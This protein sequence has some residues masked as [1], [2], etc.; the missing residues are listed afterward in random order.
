MKCIKDAKIYK[1][2]MSYLKDFLN[3]Y[4]FIPSDVLQR[5]IEANI[6][7]LCNFRRSI[8]EIGI[9]NGEISAGLFK[10]HSQID[11]GIDVDNSGLE[12]ARATNKYKK[13]FCINAENM[14]FKSASFN[15]VVS[16][17]SFEHII[18]DLKAVSEV[19][20]VLKKGGYF[21]VTVP[22]E[23]LPQWVLS[24]EEKRNKNTAKEKL[25]SFNNRTQHFHYHSF[26]EWRKVF[27]KNNLSIVFHKYYF[28]QE[29]I[30]F[31]YKLFKIFT[32]TINK[33]ELWS[34]IGH[35]KVS[36]IIPKKVVINLLGKRFLK[37]VYKNAFFTNSEEGG[38]L[39]MVAQKK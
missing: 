34:Y 16:N 1:V 6:W 14:P 4:W 24:Y 38:Q 13:V 26:S 3:K 17:S 11:V 25:E 7:D 9:G 32:R 18:S 22:S 28:S 23:Y 19:A 8:L 33:R 29:T 39:F 10:K 35:S 21:F 30:F 5:S 31:W 15:T 2:K 36:H 27:L 37:D 12:T 20:R